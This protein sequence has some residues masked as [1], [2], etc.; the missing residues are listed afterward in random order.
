M[1]WWKKA[2]DCVHL[3]LKFTIQNAVLIVSRTK[4]KSKM[5]P[6]RAS[7]S[8]V[9]FAHLH[10]HINSFA[11]FSVLNIWQCL[12]Y[13][14]LD[15]CS[16]ICTVT[17]YYVLHQTNS[18]FWYI[19]NSTYSVICRY[20]KSY[21]VLLR[22]IHAY[23]EIIKTYSSLFRDIQPLFNPCIFTTLPY[24]VRRQIWNRRLF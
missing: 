1:A 4:K 13:V 24:S 6:W 21:P 11:K 20:V 12:E 19:Q 9:L 17:L 15:N 3:W 22:H 5:F 8:C 14:C 7:F 16:V 2:F 10:S 23:T 18:E